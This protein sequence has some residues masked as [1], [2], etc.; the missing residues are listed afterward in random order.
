M[1]IAQIEQHISEL[2]DEPKTPLNDEQR[3][4]AYEFATGLFAGRLGDLK[5]GTSLTLGELQGMHALSQKL[6]FYLGYFVEDPV[7][8]VDA[9]TL[10]L[11]GKNEAEMIQ[12]LLETGIARLLDQHKKAAER[13]SAWNRR[14]LA[15]Q[16][17]RPASED[18]EY[19]PGTRLSV[20]YNPDAL[21]A[22]A[23]A[24]HAYRQFYVAAKAQVATEPDDRL[25]HAKRALLH[26]YGS[27]LRALA[28]VDVYPGLLSLEEQL[29]NSRKTPQVHDWKMRLVRIAPAI[30][31]IHQMSGDERRNARNTFALHLDAIRQGAPLELD[32]IDDQAAMVFGQQAL[33]QLTEA[34]DN[35]SRA[36][37]S[38]QPTHLARELEGITWNAEQI[39][40]FF[41]TV[42]G[43]WDMLSDHSALWQ[44]VDDRDGFAADEKFQV[45]ITPR[46]KNMSVDSTRRI[47]NIPEDTL[48]PLVGLYPAGALPLIAHELS[49]VLQAY[50]DYELG[51][52]IPLARIK[53]H[54]YRILRE[55]G[56]S[57]Q[58][59]VLCRDYFGIGREPNGHYVRAY[60]AKSNGAS[61]LGVARAFYASVNAGKQLTPEEDQAARDFAVNRTARLYRHGGHNSQVLDYVEQAVVCDVLFRHLTPEQAN[62]FLLGSTSFS[63]PDS[64]LLHRFG[65]LTLPSRAAFNPAQDVMRV[66]SEQFMPVVSTID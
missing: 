14:R 60:V 40:Q 12:A 35:L 3:E 29:T 44:E 45:I 30:G 61:R 6:T 58:E 4:Q 24:L 21:L 63:L 55:A 15:D 26:V 51:Q 43:E 11:A 7:G 47:V 33:T 1:T 38:L 13:S 57:Y 59:R 9:V 48:R 20:N 5:A 25:A 16:L 17:V 56:G 50:A 66:F 39:K 37:D 54:R 22:K 32:D 31:Q 28:A 10:G 46:R 19:Q 23:E 2:L 34:V 49:H 62:A 36:A 27:R 18:D 8:H 65:L 64:A 52:Q 53:G 42:L 41:E